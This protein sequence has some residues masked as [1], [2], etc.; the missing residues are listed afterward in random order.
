MAKTRA[1]RKPKRATHSA[2]RGRTIK[3]NGGGETP[4]MVAPEPESKVT[5]GEAMRLAVEALG[6][7]VVDDELAPQQLRE[8][9]SFYEEV[10][11]RQAAYD[12]KAEEAKTAKKGLESAQEL[13]LERVKS[14]THPSPLPLFDETEREA[15]QDAMLDS[16]TEGGESATA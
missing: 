1:P 7:V 9:G 2:N 6:D 14:F 3:A 15:D 10:T 13:L 5:I 4:L 11:R 12:A 8:L 16:A